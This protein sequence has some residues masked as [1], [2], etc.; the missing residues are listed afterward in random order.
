MNFYYHF[1]TKL[2]WL[3]IVI[4]LSFLFCLC[5]SWI[6]L[7][8]YPYTK[9]PYISDLQ[10]EIKPCQAPIVFLAISHSTDKSH[11]EWFQRICFNNYLMK[12][13][14]YKPYLYPDLSITKSN[15]FFYNLQCYPL[16][17]IHVHHYFYLFSD[18]TILQWSFMPP[19][20]YGIYNTYLWRRKYRNIL[21]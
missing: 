13:N 21:H 2:H 8:S 6:N 12:V 1:F 14:K 5:F 19:M 7:G 20:F 18:A 17:H 10:L 3:S 11:S 16:F 15:D 9:H 4:L